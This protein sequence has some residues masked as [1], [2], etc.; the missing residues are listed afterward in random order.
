MID[1]PD[2]PPLRVLVVDD[3]PDTRESLGLLL[4]LWGHDVRLAAD[5]PA[6]L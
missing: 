3:C 1:S 5:G 2:S 6:A 4:A